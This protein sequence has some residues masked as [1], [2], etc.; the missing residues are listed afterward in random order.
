MVSA[1]E[2]PFQ[3]EKL[4]L[5]GTLFE[6][7]GAAAA[8]GV[9][10][11]H[12]L[13]SDQGG[14]RER[15]EAASERLGAVCLT[16]D[17]GGHGGS[18]GNLRELTARSHLGDVL[19]AFDVL[20]SQPGVVPRRIGVCG[21]SYGAYLTALLT[22]ERPTRGLLLRAPALYA[23]D[24]LDTPIERL[25]RYDGEVTIVESA[26]DE[27]ISRATIDAYL[28]ACRRASHHVIPDTGHVLKDPAARSAFLEL[29]VSWA[30]GL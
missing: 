14:Y 9:L 1:R 7:A 15:A 17:L 13:R 12:R 2:I 10:F 29:V 16:F 3:S 27:V 21:A 19:A 26:L 22:A 5:A 30:A 28:A 8:P 18:T 6:P 24:D 25:G 11:V 23:D 4:E 20:A